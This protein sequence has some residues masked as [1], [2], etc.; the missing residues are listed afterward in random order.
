[1]EEQENKRTL[2][3][4]VLVSLAVAVLIIAGTLWMGHNARTATEDSVRAVSMMYL[5]ELAGRRE[6][7]IATNLQNRINDM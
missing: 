3:L 5:D 6:Q 2:R 1:M 4:I 7:V